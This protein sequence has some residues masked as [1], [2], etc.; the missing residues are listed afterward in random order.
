MLQTLTSSQP[1]LRQAEVGLGIKGA[2]GESCISRSATRFT[3]GS[4]LI[5]TRGIILKT[6]SRAL[7]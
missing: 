2:A 7:L 5:F 1:P 4:S 3:V 6:E